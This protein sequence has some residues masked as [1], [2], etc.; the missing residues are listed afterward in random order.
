MVFIQSEL[1]QTAYYLI[2][3]NSMLLQLNVSIRTLD[4]FVMPS[5]FSTVAIGISFSVLTAS[6]MAGGWIL[7]GTDLS[8]SYNKRHYF[9]LDSWG[10]FFCRAFFLVHRFCYVCSHKS[11][12]C[13]SCGRFSTLT[14][15]LLKS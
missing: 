4:D 14:P 2:N 8:L 3:C 10:M 7:L 1:S 12:G 13:G 15:K 6:N 5:P 11:C 9:L